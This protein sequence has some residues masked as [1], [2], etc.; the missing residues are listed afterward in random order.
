MVKNPFVRLLKLDI[1][2][3]P[4]LLPSSGGYPWQVHPRHPHPCSAR[5][6]SRHSISVV[7]L[8]GVGDGL[9][10]D[11]SDVSFWLVV[12]WPSMFY[13]PRN[14]GG[15]K[16]SQ[17]TWT[18]SSFSEGV[19][20]PTT[21]QVLFP[22]RNQQSCRPWAWTNMATK[23]VTPAPHCFNGVTRRDWLRWLL[24]VRIDDVPSF[25]PSPVQPTNEQI[26]CSLGL[27]CVSWAGG[28]EGSW[29]FPGFLGQVVDWLLKHLSL[30]WISWVQHLHRAHRPMAKSWLFSVT[31][32]GESHR[33]APTPRS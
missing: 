19:Q 30:P 10:V 28:S 9:W 7:F 6:V 21:K 3:A 11:L 22:S 32:P 12:W 2:E 4:T 33:K 29:F 25:S 18:H 17:L 23:I 26:P 15:K 20:T 16:S 1:V 31:F 27:D 5:A 13:F 14:I 24:D 8:G